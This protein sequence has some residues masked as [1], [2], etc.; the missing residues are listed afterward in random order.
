VRS[1][2]HSQLGALGRSLQ[3]YGG[4]RLILSDCLQLFDFQCSFHLRGPLCAYDRSQP[5]CRDVSICGVLQPRMRAYPYL[6]LPAT[7][8]V[9][10]SLIDA[11]WVLQ[12][13]DKASLNRKN[14][15]Q[16][17]EQSE[18]QNRARYKKRPSPRHEIPEFRLSLHS[19]R[20]FGG[21][22]FRMLPSIFVREA[23]NDSSLVGM[24]R[25]TSFIMQLPR[26]PYSIPSH[27]D[28]S[29]LSDLPQVLQGC[30]NCGSCR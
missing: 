19:Y 22:A 2:A 6:N 3:T 21:R 16:S 13:T 12:R 8:F 1:G 26:G 25:W 27:S 15:S 30:W 4:I 28:S 20:N 17:S 18:A 5:S 11:L 29:V 23:T 14:R 9:R 10:D 7:C 24:L